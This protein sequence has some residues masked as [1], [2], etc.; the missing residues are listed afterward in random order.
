MNNINLEKIKQLVDQV[1]QE[2]FN[3]QL[4]IN[5][6]I[7]L[8]DTSRAAAY[9]STRVTRL[10]EVIIRT[11][12]CLRVSKNYN[13]KDSELKNT[14]AHELIHVY[15]CQIL[16]AKGGHGYNFKRKMNE[17]NK[18]EG[19]HVT[20][21]HSMETTKVK[22]DK[23]VKYVVSEQNRRAAFVSAEVLANSR[24][25]INFIKDFGNNSKI[26]EISYLELKKAG[27]RTFKQFGKYYCLNKPVIESKLKELGII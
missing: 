6:P 13:W 8:C 25:D 11:V 27:F 15:E 5:F 21:R 18:I 4:K 9:V 10:D 23:T 16:K 19:Y 2:C 3:N 22:K 14:I 20:V 26:G 17:I 24:Y 12:R 7:E 1:N